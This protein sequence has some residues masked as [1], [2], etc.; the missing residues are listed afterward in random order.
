MAETD[1]P[2]VT[3]TC[4]NETPPEIATAERLR[5][6]LARYDLRRWRFTDHVRIEDS[7]IPHSHPVLTLSTP[8]L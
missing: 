2:D 1:G 5:A 4:V 7:V 6:L 3:I 8:P